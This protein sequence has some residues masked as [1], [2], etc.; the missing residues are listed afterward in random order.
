MFCFFAC[1]RAYEGEREREREGGGGGGEIGG[2]VRRTVIKRE[3]LTRKMIVV[4]FHNNLSITCAAYIQ[5]IFWRGIIVFCNRV[6]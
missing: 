1:V 2:I 5:K 6:F 3:K 4:Y